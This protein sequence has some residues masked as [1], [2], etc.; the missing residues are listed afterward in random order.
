MGDSGRR[1]RRG[2]GRRDDRGVSI[3]LTHALTL[4]ITTILV[5]G[6][7]LSSGPFLEAQE[8]RVSQDQLSEIGSN[9]AT[10]V[11]TLDRLA[12]SGDDVTTTVTVQYPNRIVDTHT[13]TVE[14][15]TIDDGGDERALVQISSPGVDRASSFQLNTEAEIEDSTTDG[16]RVEISLCDDGEDSTITLDGCDP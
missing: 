7:L 6:L 1:R 12:D 14:L 2:T 9:V 3:A 15:R 4:A 11:A 16:P 10:Q 13:Y 5:G 8:Q